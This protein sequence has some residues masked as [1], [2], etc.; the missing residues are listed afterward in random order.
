MSFDSKTSLQLLI[1]AMDNLEIRPNHSL[2][3]D[4]WAIY[5]VALSPSRP[6][7]FITK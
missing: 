4:G 7:Q 2:T 3:A 6:Y 5:T 1:A